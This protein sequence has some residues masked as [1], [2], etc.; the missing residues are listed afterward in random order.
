MK[1]ILSQIPLVG[2][3]FALGYLALAAVGLGDANRVNFEKASMG[4][5]SFIG[6]Q[7][8]DGTEDGIIRGEDGA[9]TKTVDTA[10]PEFYADDVD[11][12]IVEKF[13]SRAPLTTL[14][15]KTNR[16]TTKSIR[17]KFFSRNFRPYNDTVTTE[18]VGAAQTEFDVVVGNSKMWAKRD[19]ITF[20]GVPGYQID[21]VNALSDLRC[22][23]ID[24]NVNATT[25]Q[26]Q[27]INGYRATEAAV[28]VLKTGDTITALTVIA[29]SSTGNSELQV[30]NNPYAI[31]PVPTYNL[32]QK[33]ILT[34]KES[35]W[36]K[37]QAKEVDYTKEDMINDSIYDFKG[38]KETDLYFGSRD[39][40]EVTNSEGVDEDVQYAGGIT[41]FSKNKIVMSG[42]I[43]NA[44]FQD[45]GRQISEGN[46][47][48]NERVLLMGSGAQ[49]R[50]ATADD[51]TK[52]M[53]QENTKVVH[54]LTFSQIR[55]NGLTLNCI[56]SPM[57]DES[58][59]TNLAIWVD[60]EYIKEKYFEMPKK[61]DINL[62][63]QSI[64][65]AQQT[66][67]SESSTFFIQYPETHGIID[68]TFIA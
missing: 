58:G 40:I 30:E 5:V 34:I 66:N 68:T 49:V 45:M 59:N 35:N 57:L 38:A 64:E 13:P 55:T 39:I 48:N 36:A 11:K 51:F 21:V 53:T 12:K 62:E 3:I 42:E 26:V 19:T 7:S 20:K 24:A 41:A 23:V 1:K 4:F 46:A 8:G 16:G 43:T 32:I 2:L 18:I 6:N 17:P 67:Y 15:G 65:A 47:G 63:D 56:H 52:Q 61:K 60:L 10:S 9:T 28:P 54:G 25:I 27:P 14:L 29:R 31:F 50:L 33:R 37:V 44:V 22:I